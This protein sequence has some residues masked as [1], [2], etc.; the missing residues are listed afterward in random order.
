[1]RIA[2]LSGALLIASG[3]TLQAQNVAAAAGG[4]AAIAASA[5]SGSVSDTLRARGERPWWIVV[6]AARNSTF[7]TREGI[8]S[9]DVMT[10]T[11]GTA[12][13]RQLGRHWAIDYTI[14]AI[15]LTVSSRT[16]MDLREGRCH[17]RAIEPGEPESSPLCP[18]LTYGTIV[19]AG[20]L[21]LG[22]QLVA[23][24]GARVGLAARAAAGLVAFNRPIPDPGAR[25][26]NFLVG[27]SGGVEFRLRNQ[28]RISVG[29]RHEHVSNA[30][31]ADVNPGLNAR[32][33][34]LGMGW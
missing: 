9:R 12:F 25:R 22:L 11:F 30:G 10:V 26:V 14:D 20:V 33:I 31:T 29:Y 24:P 8:R 6:S 17:E 27:I 3:E 4:G 28:R 15:P 1:M 7:K 34:F 18:R 32:M 23:F 2:L 13:R 5:P 21:P 16:P 19:G